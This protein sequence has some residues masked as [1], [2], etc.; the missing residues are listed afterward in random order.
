LPSDT[1]NLHKELRKTYHPSTKNKYSKFQRDSSSC[2]G[3][4]EKRERG[5]INAQ[6]NIENVLQS[7]SI[8]KKYVRSMTPLQ[9]ARGESQTR[10]I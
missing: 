8:G 3:V 6:R 1:K 9:K 2:K 5:K 7:K 4:I 10:S